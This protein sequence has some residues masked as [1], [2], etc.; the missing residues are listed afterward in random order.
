MELTLGPVRVYRNKVNG[1]FMKGHPSPHKGRKWDEWLTKEQQAKILKNLRKPK[2]NHHCV[3]GWNKKPVIMVD[4]DNNKVY[5]PSAEEAKRITGI[6]AG[7]ICS[8]CRGER[9]TAG[10]CKWYWYNS[11]N[12]IDK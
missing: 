9:H 11:D 8:C 5:F 1:Q 4:K 6:S 12:W 2:T 3:A 7:N 10:G